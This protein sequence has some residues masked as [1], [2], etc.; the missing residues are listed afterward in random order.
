MPAPALWQV[1]KGIEGH[2]SLNAD[3]FQSLS[4]EAAS[5]FVH[6]ELTIPP[7]APD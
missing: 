1:T 7:R 2:T 6:Q 3:L 4:V 5:E